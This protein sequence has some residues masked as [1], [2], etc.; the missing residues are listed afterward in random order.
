MAERTAEDRLREE[1]F[2]LLPAARRVLEELEAE[3]RHSLL[4]L[5]SELDSYERLV[6]T[7]LQ[8]RTG[9]PSERESGTW[10]VPG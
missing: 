3:V 1:Y 6:V 5:S 2:M 8:E 9:S 10:T 4:P 7:A